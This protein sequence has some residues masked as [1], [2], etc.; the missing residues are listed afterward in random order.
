MSAMYSNFPPPGNAT[1]PKP[2]SHLGI[3][4]H[5]GGDETKQFFDFDA[6]DPPVIGSGLT[7]LPCDTTFDFGGYVT[8][9]FEHTTAANHDTQES[10]RGFGLEDGNFADSH[11]PN[12][13]SVDTAFS[14]LGLGPDWQC[15]TTFDA[16][17][18]L[19][20]LNAFDEAVASGHPLAAER[21]N[22][23]GDNIPCENNIRFE[24]GITPGDDI[25]S[26]HAVLNIVTGPDSFRIPYDQRHHRSNSFLRGPHLALYQP[27]Q[28]VLQSHEININGEVSFRPPTPLKSSKS[29][30]TRIGTSAKELLRDSFKSNP[31][32]NDDDTS[33]L[34]RAT[35]LTRRTVKTWF[36]NARARKRI[37]ERK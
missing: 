6:W 20:D 19:D 22:L 26:D 13:F 37:F 15:P 35:Q 32:P 18:T 36:S 9:P 31:Y 7:V 33:F 2:A 5:H 23:P 28:P 25:A 14:D 24:N 10:G 27:T 1:S 17:M 3:S 4:D 16:S 8:Q 30:R 12:L 29:R 21:I 11:L 34:A